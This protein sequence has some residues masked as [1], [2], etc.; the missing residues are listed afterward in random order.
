MAAA[1]LV[2]I[3]AL[4]LKQPLRLK[5]DDAALTA[6]AVIFLLGDLNIL[7]AFGQ[8]LLKPLKLR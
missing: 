2:A 5:K 6:L 4:L 8:N 7:T 3:A 1:L